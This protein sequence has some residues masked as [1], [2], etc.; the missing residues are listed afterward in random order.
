VPTQIVDDHNT[1]PTAAGIE[2]IGIPTVIDVDP[3]ALP[4]TLSQSE[5]PILLTHPGVDLGSAE[6]LERPIEDLE[7]VPE[8]L[9][10]DVAALSRPRSSTRSVWIFLTLVLFLGLLVQALWLFR[11][12]IVSAAP[13]LQPV[14]KKVCTYFHC[15]IAVETAPNTIEL[16]A[17]DVR[18][19]PQFRNTLLVTATL[20]SRSPLP[21]KY[22]IVQLGLYGQM[23][24]AI[25]I[26]RFKP[27][28]Y[29][30]NSMDLAAGMPSNRRIYIVFEI[31]GIGTSATS[32]EFILL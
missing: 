27:S 22:P 7:E 29:L 21:S 6:T 12:Q 28:E 10:Q 14:L 2:P 23:G 9:K 4:E 1:L 13:A 8:I 24:E 26:R 11:I 5:H 25:G 20:V 17:R 30:D 31:V 18:D 32:F 19:H 15:T 16:I 3:P